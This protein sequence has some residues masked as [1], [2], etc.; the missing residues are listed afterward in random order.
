MTP[1]EYIK[2]VQ[3]ESFIEAVN[4]FK[5]EFMK[6]I[7]CHIS[8]VPFSIPDNEDGWTVTFGEIKQVVNNV[9]RMLGGE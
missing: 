3:N 2:S 5:A 6:R 7:K 8:P 1:E 4:A 9:S